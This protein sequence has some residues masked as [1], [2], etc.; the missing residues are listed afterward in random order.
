L[1]D[2]FASPH[3]LSVIVLMVLTELPSLSLVL[4]FVDCCSPYTKSVGI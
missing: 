1:T 2:H 3:C 4:F